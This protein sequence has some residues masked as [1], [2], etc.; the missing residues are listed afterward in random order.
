MAAKGGWKMP[1]AIEV[2]GRSVCKLHRLVTCHKCCMDFSWEDEMEEEDDYDKNPFYL[3]VLGFRYCKVHDEEV[4]KACG[5]NEEKWNAIKEKDMGLGG[6]HGKKPLVQT[7]KDAAN[8]PSSVENVQEPGKKSKKRN[9][10]KGAALDEK[11]VKAVKEEALQIPAVPAAVTKLSS[12][13][14]EEFEKEVAAL[15]QKG[16]I[17]LSNSC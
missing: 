6:K 16:S 12:S 3:D 15:L 10:K 7:V 4:C 2:N 9:K 13:E 1:E 8:K 5:V 11:D 14:I 17:E